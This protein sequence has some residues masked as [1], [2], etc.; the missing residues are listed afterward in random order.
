MPIVYEINGELNRAA[1][2]AYKALRANIQFYDSPEK[3]K[4]LAVTS[5]KPGEGK[6]TTSINL[7]VSMAKVGMEAIYID[8]DMRK[9]MIMK[10]LG[11]IELKGLSNYLSGY[12]S[13]DE[14]INQTNID[15]FSFIASGVRVAD[16]VELI[17]SEKFY[18]LL[19]FV[20]DRY[21]IAI[22]DTPPLGS[23]IDCALI[24]SF[25]DGTIIVIQPDMV[26]YKNAQMLMKQLQNANARVIG[27]VL[28]KL[29]KEEYKN[30]YE[31]FDYYGKNKGYVKEWYKT[32]K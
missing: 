4:T 11:S 7:A 20:R 9:P 29:S 23:A 13:I 6:T 16:P 24:S 18:K 22:I 5:Y 31:N 26:K 8:A 3:I 25:T 32:K 2:E 19:E 28:N 27:V 15:G 10:K 21:D 12:V 30:Y 17:Y 1:D 14:V